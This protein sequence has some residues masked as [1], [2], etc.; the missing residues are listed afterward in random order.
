MGSAMLSRPSSSAS[1]S[2][3]G[4]SGAGQPAARSSPSAASSA[5]RPAPLRAGAPGRAT[6][7][8]PWPGISDRDPL[9]AG[10]DQ[11]PR[12]FRSGLLQPPPGTGDPGQDPPLPPGRLD[13]LADRHPPIVPAVF[14]KLDALAVLTGPSLPVPQVGPDE[15]AQLAL[16]LN[17][18]HRRR[19]RRSP[20]F[21]AGRPAGRPRVP[22]I[23]AP[24]RL[25]FAYRRRH[26]GGRATSI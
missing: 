6:A 5:S 8:P 20:A 15:L 12:P 1:S 17:D 19:H 9:G 18:Q 2:L 14:G 16:I 7:R 25:C 11:R 21:P 3:P 26:A 4:Y 23:P 10:R 22:M 13:P 24:T